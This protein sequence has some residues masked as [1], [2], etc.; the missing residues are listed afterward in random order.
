MLIKPIRLKKKSFIR[1]L[2]TAGMFEI[3]ANYCTYFIVVSYIIKSVNMMNSIARTH[4][5]PASLINLAH[6]SQLTKSIRQ[7]T[8]ALT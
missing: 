3:W 4:I 5:V 2:Q 8:A 7:R 1:F 6:N